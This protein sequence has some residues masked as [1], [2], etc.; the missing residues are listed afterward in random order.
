[1]K[2]GDYQNMYLFMLNIVGISFLSA[3]GDMYDIS[4]D[5]FYVFH[6][7][8]LKAEPIFVKT[9]PWVLKN[10]YEF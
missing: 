2:T 7:R 5:Q 9:F 8:V 10:F 1:M 3:Q 6:K 4:Q